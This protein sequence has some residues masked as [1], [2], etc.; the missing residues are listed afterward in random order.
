MVVEDAVV[1]EEGM[2]YDEDDFSAEARRG[3]LSTMPFYIALF[4]L[5]KIFLRKPFFQKG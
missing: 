5:E 4:F 3:V 1:D 2:M